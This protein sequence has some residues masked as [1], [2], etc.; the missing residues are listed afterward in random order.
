MKAI[1]AD[2]MPELLPLSAQETSKVLADH[3]CTYKSI[4]GVV[5]LLL[6]GCRTD[7]PNTDLGGKS[8]PYAVVE[9]NGFSVKSLIQMDTLRPQW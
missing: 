2:E 4:D 7:V 9:W 5:Q 3:G 6:I 1:I 8:D